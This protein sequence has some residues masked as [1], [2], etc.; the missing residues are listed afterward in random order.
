M[1]IAEIASLKEVPAM[2][3]RRRI[4]PDRCILH[5]VNRG[6][7]KKVIFPEPSDYAA[8]LVLLREARE[9]Y[10]VQ[11]YGYE[12]MPNHF[13]LVTYVERPEEISAYMHWIQRVHA[14][15]LRFLSR[16]KGH[17]HIFQ[18]RYWSSVIE[19]EVHL[20]NVLRYVEGNALRAGLVE[21]AE[22]WEW[23]SLWDRVTG[24]RDLL[25]GLP[26][27][28]PE[29]WTAIVNTPQE[30]MELETLRD[31]VRPGRPPKNTRLTQT[32]KM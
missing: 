5:I 2:P 17:G 24:E 14:C 21:A 9:R 3:S 25:H 19:G 8:F 27:E 26:F 1:S 22:D 12:L 13:H 7:D 30:K 11:L 29:D 10:E 18:R 6:N 28:L 31:P 32:V 20:L 16:T 4:V 15:D 23:G